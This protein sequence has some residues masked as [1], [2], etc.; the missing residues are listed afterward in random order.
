MH[1]LL[2]VAPIGG[3]DMLRVG[4]VVAVLG[5]AAGSAYLFGA[6]SYSH[7]IPP[8]PQI[9]KIIEPGADT[10]PLLEFDKYRRLIGYPGKVEIPCPE[11]T[12]T[13]MVLLIIGQSN[14]ANVAGQRYTS[15]HGPKVLNYFDGSC[16]IASSPLLGANNSAGESWTLLGNKLISAGLA[17]TVIL[18]SSAIGR[19]TVERWSSGDL[20]V[21]L[22]DVLKEL[23][24]GIT[25]VLW[26][27]GEQDFVVNTPSDDYVQAFQTIASRFTAPVF[28]SVA[29]WCGLSPDWTP[30]NPT[31]NAQRALPDGVKIFAG[32]DTDTL[33]DHEDRYED[34]HFSGSGQEKFADAWVSILQSAASREIQPSG[35]NATRN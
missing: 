8:L 3:R 29:S 34:C 4:I 9:L 12:S 33:M 19:S 28:V 10:P 27:Q 31:A 11:Q 23:Q 22:D 18:V 14:A 35:N 24:Y 1:E 13:T 6:Y 7:S 5:A 26:H 32:V 25:Y 15:E 16:Y 21:M 20:S 17:D 30:D 2:A